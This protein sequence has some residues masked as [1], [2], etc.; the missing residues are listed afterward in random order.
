MSRPG[1]L[2]VAAV[3]LVANAFV[4]VRVAQNRSATVQEMELTERELSLQFAGPENS[5]IGLVLNWIDPTAPWYWPWGSGQ[6]TTQAGWLNEAKLRELGFDVST[7]VNTP[8]A[9]VK[10]SHVL[11]RD[12]FVVLQYEGPEWEAWIKKREQEAEQCPS[13]LPGSDPRRMS[14]LIAIDVGRDPTA[15]RHRYP[16]KQRFLIVRGVVRLFYQKVWHEQQHRLS[17]KGFL[18]GQI[19]VT[20]REIHVPLPHASPLSSLPGNGSSA[21]R[22]VVTLRYGTRFEPWVAAVRRL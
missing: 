10:Y 1:L 20:N 17:D 14:H 15:L 16:E 3:V 22:Y 8:E 18:R 2:L 12:A 19:E 11:P 9:D 4:L 21:P 5:G 7:P 6:P 13:N